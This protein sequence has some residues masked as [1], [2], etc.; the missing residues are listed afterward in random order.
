MELRYVFSAPSMLR[1]QPCKWSEEDKDRYLI[2]NK[3]VSSSILK[4]KK[5]LNFN[6]EVITKFD[7]DILFNAYQEAEYG[8]HLKE[9]GNFTMDKIYSDSGGLQMVTTGKNITPELKN[10]IYDVQSKDSDY[11]MCFDEI[12]VISIGSPKKLS[13]TGSKLYVPSLKK[14]CAIK[15]ALN[16]KEQIES[17][18]KNNSSTKVF[19]IVQGNTIE[20]MVEWFDVAVETLPE[21]YW[22]YIQGIA[23]ASPCMGNKQLETIDQ[24]VSYHLIREKYGIKK[25]K[26][27]LHLLGVGSASRLFPTFSLYIGGLLPKDIT[28]SFDSTSFSMSQFMGNFSD[29]FGNSINPKNKQYIKNMIEEHY[30]FIEEFI[31]DNKLNIIKEDFLEHYINSMKSDLL[32]FNHSNV[33]IVVLSRVMSSFICFKRLIGLNYQI[34]SFI[35]NLKKDNSPIGLL[36]NVK[37]YDSYKNW[38]N[39]FGR[40]VSSNRIQRQKTTLK[41]LYKN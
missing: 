16:V 36:K 8:L 6:K 19:Y 34:N 9:N 11:A 29:S 33:D 4:I 41:T 15:T 38:V 7:I 39:N 2:Y 1:L 10:K 37:D 22:D 26:N 24:I 40:Y 20:D 23:L 18:I 13:N 32:L 17:F 3:I 25:V 31:I 21:E 14:E 28:L 12:P 5:Q 30:D 35:N 27:H